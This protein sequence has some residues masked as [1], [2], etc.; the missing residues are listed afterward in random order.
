MIG[1]DLALINR[2][3]NK[4]DLAKKILT[5]E[6]YEEYL[7]SPNKKEFLAT[8]FASKEAFLKA[9][10]VGLFQI[11]FKDICIRH[12]SNGC[13]HIIYQ[14]KEDFEI[15]ISHEGEYVISIVMKK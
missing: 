4:D 6:E 14:N 2:F 5:D 11:P 10:K 12:D 9:N 7:S 13:P 8:R 1:I 15:S 3:E